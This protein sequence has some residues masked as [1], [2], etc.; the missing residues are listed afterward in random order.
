MIEPRVSLADG[1][2]IS[3]LIARD[4]SFAAVSVPQGG[5]RR[6]FSIILVLILIEM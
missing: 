3:F 5:I 2:S 6:I 4:F 1:L